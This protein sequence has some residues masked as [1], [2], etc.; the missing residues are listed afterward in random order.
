MTPTTTYSE[1]LMIPKRIHRL[2]FG[3]RP[4]P[5]AYQEYGVKWAAMHPDWELTDWTYDNLPPLRNQALFDTCGWNWG[6]IAG[7]GK[8]SSAVAVQRADI[9]AYEL[10]WRFGGVYVNCDLEP[11]KPLN[12]LC[13]SDGPL[14]WASA[15]PEPPYISNAILAGTKQHPFWDAVIRILP[16]HVAANPMRPMNQQ[17]GPFLLTDVA[18]AVDGL[19]VHDSE[20]FHPY[21][22][23]QMA[24]EGGVFPD[25]YTEHHWGHRKPDTDLWNEDDDDEVPVPRWLTEALPYLRGMGVKV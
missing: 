24:V 3:P 7:A 6:G 5:Q 13:D 4:M 10:V 17:T 2:W 25:A 23:S 19:T 18:K 12:P 1:Q 11:L 15:S 20:L 22:Y 21:S 14:A 8:Q 9:A 16:L